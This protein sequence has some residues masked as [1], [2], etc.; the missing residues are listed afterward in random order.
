M[1]LTVIYY[2]IYLVSGGGNKTQKQGFVGG[3]SQ[4]QVFGL[5]QYQVTQNTALFPVG[6]KDF[7]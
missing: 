2:S 6:V 3:A 7:L 4:L 1:P 5:C